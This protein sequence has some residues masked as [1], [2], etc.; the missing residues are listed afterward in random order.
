[1]EVVLDGPAEG[2]A[3]V[4]PD[5]EIVFDSVAPV[6]AGGTG[7]IDVT[8]TNAGDTTYVGDAEIQV[9]PGIRFDALVEGTVT[10]NDPPDDSARCT[11]EVPAGDT[12]DFS[13]RLRL[14][15]SIVGRLVIASEYADEDFE[16]QIFAASRLLYSGVAHGRILTVGNTL[17]TCSEADPN[18]APARDGVGDVLNRWDL[19]AQF[20]GAMPGWANSSSATVDLTAGSVDAAYLF[21]SGDLNERGVEIPDDGSRERVSVLP[22]GADAPVEVAAERVRLGDVDATQ[23][24]GTA[25]VTAL[26]AQYGSGDYLVGNVRSV[27]VQGSYAG[28][29]MVVVVDDAT[30]PRRALTVTDPFSWFAPTDTYAVE[31]PVPPGVDQTLH[32][33]VIGFEGERSFVPERMT[34]DGAV[35]GDSAFDSTIDGPRSPSYDNNFGMD[36]DA[37]DLVIDAPDGILPITA[38]SDK[39]GVRLAVLALAIDVE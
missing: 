1:M 5:L 14:E 27:E 33:G 36:I 30:L 19:P 28:W 15:S 2:F 10:C 18:C 26:V 24:F 8:V 13:V 3:P 37:Y 22:P 12:V 39:D 23:Y 31:F 21:W 16:A 25:D 38:T 7:T 6:Y 9:P 11:V 32:L 34:F 29:G 20:V 17:M 4:A 35:V